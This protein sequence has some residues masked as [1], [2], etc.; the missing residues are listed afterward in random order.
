MAIT[1]DGLIL[2]DQIAWPDR[3]GWSTHLEATGRSVGGLL[4]SAASTRSYGRPITLQTQRMANGWAG[5]VTYS[6]TDTDL[7]TVAALLELWDREP[8]DMA[9]V[10]GTEEF[11]VRWDHAAGGFEFALLE[12]TPAAAETPAAIW[13]AVTLH[14]YTVP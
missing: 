10:I 6:D 4:Y 7:A 2:P 14:L 5:P 8:Q 9:L 12:P 11:A 1:L 13:Y 3:L